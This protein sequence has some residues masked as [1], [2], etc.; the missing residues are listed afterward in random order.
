MTR[1]LVLLALLSLVLLVESVWGWFIARR[2]RELERRQLVLDLVVE[3]L[4]I[5]QG[6]VP[7]GDA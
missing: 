7:R 6:F 1:E 2:M 5:A 4:C 3:R